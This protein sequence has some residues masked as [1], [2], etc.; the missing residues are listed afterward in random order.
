MYLSQQY[1]SKRALSPLYGFID[2]IP[3]RPAQ[4]SHFTYRFSHAFACG[5][6]RSALLLES[7]AQRTLVKSSSSSPF[8]PQFA[9]LTYN[10]PEQ[11]YIHL[12]HTPQP[13]N[14]VQHGTISGRW[15]W[16]AQTNLRRYTKPRQTPKNVHVPRTHRGRRRLI[17]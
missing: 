6:C 16:Q 7:L 15:I 5:S 10:K 12:R 8:Q 13:H 1:G 4:H 14:H 11:S 2:R 3:A 9:L 17:E